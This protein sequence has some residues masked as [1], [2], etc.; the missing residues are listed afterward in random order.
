MS[1]IPETRHSLIAR[2]KDPGDQ[3]AWEEFVEIYRPV[4]YRVAI[5]SGI[6]PADAQDVCQTVM[7]SVSQ[8]VERWE[9]DS[10]RAKFR[11][12]LNRIAVNATVN[13]VTRRKPDKGTGDTKSLERLAQQ[14]DFEGP[15]SRLVQLEYR[16]E[17]FR[18][19]ARQIQPEFELKTW[20]AF[21]L[22]AVDGLSAN[23]AAKQLGRKTGSVYT[24]R[25]RV[26]KRL[27]D[28]VAGMTNQWDED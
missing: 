17:C 22:T 26:M 15:S 13:L 23:S 6:Q 28:R 20:Q 8:A 12:W 14:P 27:Q 19:A 1:Y 3:Q 24:A 25:C 10:T 2:L 7:V 4:V 16:R 21:W 18:I 5:H 9:P 11:T